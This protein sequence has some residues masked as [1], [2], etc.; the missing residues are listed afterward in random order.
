MPVCHFGIGSSAEYFWETIDT[1]EAL[2][3]ELSFCKR[4]LHL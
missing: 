4:H 2:K 1:E 3:T